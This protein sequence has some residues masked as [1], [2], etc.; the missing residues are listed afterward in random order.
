MNIDRNAYAEL[1][2]FL[3][4]KHSDQLSTQLSVLQSA[5]VN[6]ATDHAEEISNNS[7]FRT[8]FSDICQAIGVDPL[9]LWLYSSDKKSDSFFVGLSVK[10]VEVCQETR[11]INGGLISFRE[12]LSRLQSVNLPATITESD[13]DKALASLDSLGSGY[14]VITIH[15]KKWLN[16]SASTGT[17][18]N[19]ERSVYEV[20]TFMGGYATTRLLRDNFGWDKVRCQNV[21]D[22]M[23]MNGFLWLDKGPKESQYWEPSW[24]SG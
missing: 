10:I 2:R 21:L 9:E 22:D 20:C 1:G 18:T 19:D 24:I 6:F 8:K 17:I 7:E 15:N 5:V 12:L 11:D 14:N 23:I 13:V 3:S 16:F 4:E